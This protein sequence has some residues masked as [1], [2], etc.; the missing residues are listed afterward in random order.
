MLIPFFIP[1]ALLMLPLS[2]R[3]FLFKYY[4]ERNRMF[5]FQIKFSHCA[6]CRFFGNSARTSIFAKQSAYSVTKYNIFCHCFCPFHVAFNSCLKVKTLECFTLFLT[7][8]YETQ[9]FDIILQVL[10]CDPTLKYSP[11]YAAM[12]SFSEPS[13]N[14]ELRNSLFP[15]I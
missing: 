9:N 10:E 4:R 7:V 2:F 13:I 8:N 11:E 3:F 15:T 14:C 12:F 6:F 1:P 5:W